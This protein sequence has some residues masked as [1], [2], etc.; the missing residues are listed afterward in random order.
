M[1]QLYHLGNFSRQLAEDNEN[2]RVEL[3]KTLEKLQRVTTEKNL[4]E[5]KVDALQESVNSLTEKLQQQGDT[6]LLEVNNISETAKKLQCENDILQQDRQALLEVFNSQ[7]KKI[8]LL[9]EKVAMYKAAVDEEVTANINKAV[10][11]IEEALSQTNITLE[12]DRAPSGVFSGSSFDTTETFEENADWEQPPSDMQEFKKQET[13]WEDRWSDDDEPAHST[14]KEAHGSRS[15]DKDGYMEQP[16]LASEFKD[17]LQ[18]ATMSNNLK[19]KVVIKTEEEIKGQGESSS[20]PVLAAKPPPVSKRKPRKLR[21]S[22]LNANSNEHHEENSSDGEPVQAIERKTSATEPCCEAKKETETA[23]VSE[24]HAQLTNEGKDATNKSLESSQLK[25]DES[26]SIHVEQD[27]E[28]GIGE[29][30]LTADNTDCSST[31]CEQTSSGGDGAGAGA[32][33][34]VGNCSNE[35]KH[36]PTNPAEGS[37]VEDDACDR[38]PNV[39]PG[40]EK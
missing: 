20:P 35:D 17:F 9:E 21:K 38:S 2:L 6:M 33:A 13:S 15:V 25:K 5:S 37:A 36:A 24:Q 7:Q 40:E 14:V 12:M 27:S 19:L 11:D 1:G 8:Y 32:G 29:G 3:N 31:D 30:A 34:A 4:A 39:L 10:E 28:K 16:D 26:K 22:Q 23:E 18:A